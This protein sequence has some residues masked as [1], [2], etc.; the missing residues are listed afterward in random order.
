MQIYLV[1]GAVRDK[2]LG[3]P[4]YD[5]D[6]LVVGASIEDMLGKGYTQVG[7]GFPVFLHPDSKEEYA[8]ARTERKVAAGYTG[9]TVHASPEVTL[10]EDLLRRDLTINAIAQDS[11]GK[12]FDPY[13]GQADISSG[14]LRHV[15]PAFAEDPVRILRVARFAARYTKNTTGKKFTVAPDTLEIMQA[16]V[17][18]GET[19][20]LVAERSWQELYKALQED[21][22]QRFFEVLQDCGALP[23][24]FN[25]DEQSLSRGLSAL[26]YACKLS[27]SP[28]VRFAAFTSGLEQE[29][30]STLCKQ[31]KC[32]KE[33][34]DLS[35]LVIANLDAYIRVSQL[36]P[37]KSLG[38][39]KSV[40]AYRKPERFDDFLLASEAAARGLPQHADKP[41]P[42]REYLQSIYHATVVITAKHMTRL[43]LE[44][45]AM[46]EEIDKHRAAAIVK[47]KRTYRWSYFNVKI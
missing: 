44:G 28:S 19:D 23:A 34:S 33:F 20:S 24:V 26:A 25:G 41:H 7:R 40:D 22:P 1:G 14:T 2:L 18:A 39:L 35:R 43:R 31:L 42:Q 11:D 27:D 9:F 37:P 45:K 46:A 8:L 15:S 16:M 47:I 5:H 6:W 30:A 17:E 32:P 3:F 29:Q 13:K 12:L 38:I 21:Q 36:P 4:V 10:E